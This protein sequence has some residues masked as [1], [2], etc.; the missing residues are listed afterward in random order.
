MSNL[1]TNSRLRTWR[2]CRRKHRLMYI[3]GWRPIKQGEAL[4]FGILAHTGLEAWWR[5]DGSGRLA[6][7]IDAISGRGFDQ[8]GRAHV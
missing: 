4:R 7:A 1:L 3:D 8:I 6:A 5:D 2:D